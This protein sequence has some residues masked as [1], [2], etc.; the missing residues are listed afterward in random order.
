MISLV[1]AAAENDAIGIDGRLPWHLP[2]DLRR[3]KALTLEKPVIMGRKTW[4]S[5]GRPLPGRRNIVITRQPDYHAEGCEVVAYPAAAL[6]AAAEAEEIMIIGGS[7]IYDQFLRRA[8]RIYMTRV[9]AR[10][11]G[12]AFFPGLDETWELVSAR[13]HAADDEHEYPFTFE[14]WERQDHF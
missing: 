9:H 3:F 6:L 4:E 13:R 2:D 12:D 7:R 1:V 5:I 14:L 11:D 10:F 8:E